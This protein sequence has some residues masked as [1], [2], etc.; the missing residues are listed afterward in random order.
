MPPAD[1]AI[2]ADAQA[3]EA[4]ASMPI[5]GCAVSRDLQDRLDPLGIKYSLW[6]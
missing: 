3:G 4:L 6:R 2:L 1:L 5:L